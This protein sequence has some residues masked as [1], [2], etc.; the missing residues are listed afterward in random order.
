MEYLDIFATIHEKIRDYEARTAK[1][2]TY[3]VLGGDYVK[4]LEMAIQEDF[5]ANI[6]N[7]FNYLITIKEM[8]KH[9]KNTVFGLK[10]I[11]L[12]NNDDLLLIG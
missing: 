1:E 12:E 3:V 10:L 5:F 4:L 8:L 2:P 6:M 7:K 11:I 9:Y